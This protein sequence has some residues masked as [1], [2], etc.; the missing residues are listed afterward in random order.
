[1][2]AGHVTGLFQAT[3]SVLS[4]TIILLVPFYLFHSISIS[5]SVERSSFK[6]GSIDFLYFL[7]LMSGLIYFFAIVLKINFLSNIYIYA[8]YYYYGRIHSNRIII[9]NFLPMRASFMIWYLFFYAQVH[10]AD[11]VDIWQSRLEELLAK[12][13]HWAYSLL[14]L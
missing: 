4:A 12:Y 7:I 11:L 1:M 8:M 5:S 14:Y 13:C 3:K 10:F 9:I 2:A 6:R